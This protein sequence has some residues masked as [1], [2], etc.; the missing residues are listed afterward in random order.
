M[1]MSLHE[2]AP[3]HLLSPFPQLL[4]SYP[5]SSWSLACMPCQVWIIYLHLYN[6][7]WGTKNLY[8]LAIHS[9]YR[10]L[11]HLFTFCNYYMSLA[12]RVWIILKA[13]NVMILW[14]G[15]FE[16][17]TSN[18]MIFKIISCLVQAKVSIILSILIINV[19]H[20]KIRVNIILIISQK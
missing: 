4:I 16:N 8:L 1:I 15:E 6:L 20:D 14:E 13:S 5:F 19:K 2:R 9:H 3:P 18:V 17:M 12:F 10:S 7:L 11:S